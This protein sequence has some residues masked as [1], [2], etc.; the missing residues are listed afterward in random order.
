[1][2][3]ELWEPDEAWFEFLR[4]WD[5]EGEPERPPTPLIHD[6][7]AP[8]SCCSQIGEAELGS[9]AEKRRKLDN[10]GASAEERAGGGRPT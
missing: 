9:P 5:L 7:R 10:L 2:D 8:G 1:M 4:F 6:L 3:L